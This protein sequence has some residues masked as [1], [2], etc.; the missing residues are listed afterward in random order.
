MYCGHVFHSA[1][2]IT[3]RT[4][5]Y[6]TQRVERR[7]LLIGRQGIRRVVTH[8]SWASNSRNQSRAARELPDVPG[9]CLPP[10][11]FGA[12]RCGGKISRFVVPFFTQASR[13]LVRGFNLLSK[14]YVRWPCKFNE[15][16]ATHAGVRH[17]HQPCRIAFQDCEQGGERRVTKLHS[18]Q[19]Q[20]IEA[21]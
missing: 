12:C 17:H 19:T 15:N 6:T 14:D 2:N 13:D 3:A 10:D 7:Y 21:G 8:P 16:Q 20:N 4:V 18:N 11:S 1:A 9:T 5:D